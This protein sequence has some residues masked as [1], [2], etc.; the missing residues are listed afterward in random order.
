MA[1]SRPIAKRVNVIERRLSL[2]VK[3]KIIKDPWQFAG[4]AIAVIAVV[5][6]VSIYLISRPVK[7]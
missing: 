4:V 6:T 7:L 2:G 5:V 3:M 1:Y